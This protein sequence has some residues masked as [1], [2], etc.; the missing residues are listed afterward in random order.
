MIITER[1]T[2]DRERPAVL[3]E[4]FAKE[5]EISSAARGHP[6]SGSPIICVF[7]VRFRERLFYIRYRKI[8]RISAQ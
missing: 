3:F 7:S 2:G 5:C 6:V 4:R 8:M 1:L